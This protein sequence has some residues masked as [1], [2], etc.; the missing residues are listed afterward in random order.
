MGGKRRGLVRKINFTVIKKGLSEPLNAWRIIQHQA[1]ARFAYRFL[2]GWSPPPELVVLLPTARC[3]LKCAMCPQWGE[4]GTGRGLAPSE[5]RRE[6]AFEQ[7]K[8]LVDEVARFKPQFHL[9]GGEAFLNSDLYRMLAYIKSKGLICGLTTNGTLLAD[10]ARELVS[11]GL[12]QLVVSIDGPEK[13]HDSIRGVR[14]T[15]ARATNGIREILKARKGASRPQVVLQ[16]T[17][18]SENVTI[19]REM[20]RLATGFGVDSLLIHH[21]EYTDEKTYQNHLE[22]FRKLFGI[23]TDRSW[24]GYV[25]SPEIDVEQLIAFLKELPSSVGNLE[26]NVMP[27]FTLAEVKEYYTQD[28]FVPYSYPKR[29]LFPWKGTLI[30][31]NGDIVACPNYVVGNISKQTLGEVWNGSLYR[32]LR[33]VLREKKLF[34]ICAKCCCWYYWHSF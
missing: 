2:D 15:F 30:Y 34:P 3:N 8:Q 7:V 20:I 22:V 31:P 4:V 13:I 21:L 33:Q 11:L 16:C 5:L 19:L 9:S 1:K 12:D 29:C 32:K 23:E 24:F 27:R 14:G 26:I 17:I 6:L 10:G 28:N 18:S 25:S